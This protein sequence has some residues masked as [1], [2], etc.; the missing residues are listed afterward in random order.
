VTVT[1]VTPPSAIRKGSS[2]GGHERAQ[3]KAAAVEHQRWE[4]PAICALSLVLMAQGTPTTPFLAPPATPHVRVMTW[5]VGANSV[6][7]DPGPRGFGRSDG[8]RPPR[9][10]RLVKA[11][12]PDVLCLQEVFA[13]RDASDV[14]RILDTA[15]PLAGGEH[16]VAHGQGDVVIASRFPLSMLEARSED[17]GGGVPRTHVMALIDTPDSNRDLYVICAHSQSRSE[18]KDVAARQEQADAIASWVQD[19]HRPGGVVTLAAGT[20]IV[21][22]GDWNAYK[23][24]PAAHVDTLLTGK[25]VNHARFGRGGPPDWDASPLQDAHPV[26]NG[27]RPETYTFGNGSD[28]E[29]PPAELDRVFFTDSVL[30]LLGGLVLDTTKLSAAVLA[31][32][33]LEEGDVLLHAER[34][35][36]DHLPLVVD[37][38]Y[39]GR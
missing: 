37:L 12:S 5:N 23:T 4:L 20:P 35:L 19:L 18:P 10:R 22:M 34:R 9:F 2:P 21:L 3:A 13:P 39:A 1:L 30:D 31:Q 11:V 15:I 38:A 28:V 29:Y 6:F 25:V 36:Y 14:K 17:W 27:N 26:H 32:S 33:G 8:G 24:D 7:E 16:W